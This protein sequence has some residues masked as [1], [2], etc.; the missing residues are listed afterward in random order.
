MCKTT[1]SS[2]T[3]WI[4]SPKKIAITDLNS[5]GGASFAP[6]HTFTLTLTQ[7]YKKGSKQKSLC[8][9]IKE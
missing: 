6:R 1:T 7:Y 3:G 2:K 8:I 9:E 4:L 5:V